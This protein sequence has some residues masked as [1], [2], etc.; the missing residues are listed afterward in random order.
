MKSKIAL[1]C[2]IIALALSVGGIYAVYAEGGDQG[3]TGDGEGIFP[4]KGLGMPHRGFWGSLTEEQR[5]E[6]RSEIRDLVESKLDEWGIEPP[7]PLLTEDQRAELQEY[8]EDLKEEGYSPQEIREKIAEK[9]ESWGVELPEPPI[10]RRC[11][12]R[13][14][15]M[16]KPLGG[17]WNGQHDSSDD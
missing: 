1:T 11:H 7:E 13:G 16:N 5:N 2:I 6:L 4:M 15:F 3:I 14:R 17:L 9:L 8:I 12:R 10:N